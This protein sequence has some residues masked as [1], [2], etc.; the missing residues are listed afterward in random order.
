MV[1][2][3][4]DAAFEAAANLMA[5]ASGNEIVHRYHLHV[6]GEW[7]TTGRPLR[8]TSFPHGLRVLQP[9]TIEFP[10]R[11]IDVTSRPTWNAIPLMLQ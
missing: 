5:G 8:A 9:G 3:K 7:E 1:R 2:E 6:A 11:C 10:G 4:V